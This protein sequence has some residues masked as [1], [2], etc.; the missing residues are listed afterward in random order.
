MG[1]WR[2]QP[3]AS[4]I[5][6]HASNTL[7]VIVINS[8]RFALLT[9]ESGFQAAM[10]DEVRR[11]LSLNA[12]IVGKLLSESTINNEDSLLTSIEQLFRYLTGDSHTPLDRVIDLDLDASPVE[13]VDALRVQ[14][15]QAIK[16]K[17]F[18]PELEQCMANVIWYM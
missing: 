15:A 2:G 17:R 9:Q 16:D 7:D 12:T 13:Y 8:D 3:E 14:V 11:R 18:S 5:F 4:T 10:A 1:I 6:T